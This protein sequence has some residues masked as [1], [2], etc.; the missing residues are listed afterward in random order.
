MKV[1]DLRCSHHHAFEGWFASDDE[2]LTQLERS[3]IECPLCGDKV[4]ER[5]P[6]APR[7]SLSGQA[8]ERSPVVKPTD[9]Q[10]LLLHALR[11]VLSN[12]EDVGERFPEEARRIHYGEAEERGIRGRAS[13]QEAEALAEEGIEVVPLPIPDAL[14]GPMQ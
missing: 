10:G 8:D 3:Q 1:L 14:K 11:R 6:S 7:L 13:R 4:I 9:A 12:T 2:F 5:M